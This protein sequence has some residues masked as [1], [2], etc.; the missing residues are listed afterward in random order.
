MSAGL[1]GARLSGA[2]L[3]GAWLSGAQLQGADLTGAQLQGVAISMR[4]S[5]TFE[6]RMRGR[7]G[8][9]SDLS[10]VVFAGGLSQ[11]NWDLLGEDL[12]DEQALDSL[13]E[14]LS[15]EQAEELRNRLTPHIDQPTSHELPKNSG[16]IT[17][18][19][20]AGEAE[21]WIAEYNKA[22]ANIPKAETD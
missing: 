9:E 15:A 7:I 4:P 13:V 20:T 22:M 5:S 14:D 1:Q 18:A 6:E 3:Q 21:K 12:S 2:G 8:K 10:S 17:G 16:A 19:Y 11:E